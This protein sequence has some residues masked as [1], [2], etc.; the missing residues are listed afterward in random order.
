MMYVILLND[1]AF[2]KKQFY[3][4]VVEISMEAVTMRNSGGLEEGCYDCY[5]GAV[6]LQ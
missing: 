1:G 4:M 3:I 5:V 2:E 6:P